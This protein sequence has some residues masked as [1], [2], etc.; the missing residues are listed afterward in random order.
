MPD[1]DHLYET[2]L[3][4]GRAYYRDNWRAIRRA[5]QNGHA[6]EVHRKADEVWHT[7]ATY[8]APVPAL[9]KVDKEAD[10]EG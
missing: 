10:G 9:Q 2:Q 4:E 3:R 7:E 1:L 8:I 5:Y 6:Y